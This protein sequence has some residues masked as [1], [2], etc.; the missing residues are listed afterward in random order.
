VVA[1]P[2]VTDI[3]LAN[4]ILTVN[5]GRSTMG[6]KVTSSVLSFAVVWAANENKVNLEQQ[7]PFLN[8]LT[9]RKWKCT[10]GTSGPTLKLSQ[11]NQTRSASPLR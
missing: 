8:Q 3:A 2:K 1:T 6:Q 4:G 5:T 9:R 7:Y 10:K 11:N